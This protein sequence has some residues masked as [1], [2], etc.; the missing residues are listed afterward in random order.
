MPGTPWLNS[1]IRCWASAASSAVVT[2]KEA[3]SSAQSAGVPTPPNCA[4][5]IS[6]FPVTTAEIAAEAQQ[7]IRELA[8]GVPGA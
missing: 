1:R 8:Q 4:E 6:S 7:R 5:E 2:G 3:I